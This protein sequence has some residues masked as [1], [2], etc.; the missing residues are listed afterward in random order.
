MKALKYIIIYTFLSLTFLSVKA[1]QIPVYNNYIINPF[2]YN[3]ARAGDNPNKGVLNLGFKKQWEKMPSGPI[4][5][6]ATWDSRIKATNMALGVSLTHDNI[7][8]FIQNTMASVAYN[9]RLPFK[10]DN[11]H[12]LNFGIQAGIISQK[13]N[14]TDTRAADKL[15]PFLFSAR[16]TV[17]DLSL[18]INYHYKGL[19]IGFSV[20]QVLNSKAKFRK[21]E[22]VSVFQFEREYLVLASYE[23]IFGGRDNKSWVIKPSFLFRKY[24][25]ITP[26]FDVNVLSGYKQLVWLGIGYRT[27]GGYGG[28]INSNAAGFHIMV[29]AGI[30]ERVNLFYTFEMP[31]KDVRAN[32]GYA[33]E[34]T[35][36]CNLNRKLSKK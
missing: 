20:P 31:V 29:G 8:K 19:N 9:Y 26:Q 21:D 16:A 27:G 13:L 4:T 5:A 7:G 30:K 34:I 1:Q 10:K 24:K 18:G 33:H 14:I 11:N 22:V 25:T 6:N 36:Q 17:F 12:G 3:P 15:D 23:H 35:I 32:F 28:V 2:L